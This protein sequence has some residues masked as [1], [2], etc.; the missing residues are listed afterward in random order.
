ETKCMG[1]M[2]TLHHDTRL[3]KASLDDPVKRTAPRERAVG[4]PH[5]QEAL[6][7]L[8]FG[9]TMLK[10]IQQ[11]FTHRSHQGQKGFQSCFRLSHPQSL[12]SP[13]NVMQ[14]E[15]DYLASAQAVGRQQHQD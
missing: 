9:P 10:I 12:A 8:S 1:A 5:P 14:A 6:T 2:P 13:V 11:S 15:P 3:L 4:C 7:D